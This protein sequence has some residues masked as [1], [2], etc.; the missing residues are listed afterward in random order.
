MSKKTED[1][2][3]VP[4]KDAQDADLRNQ[5]TTVE[6]KKS[7]INPLLLVVISI[8]VLV[9]ILIFSGILSF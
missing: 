5:S 8:I 1:S 2:S 6:R 9:I 4:K 7:N 3:P